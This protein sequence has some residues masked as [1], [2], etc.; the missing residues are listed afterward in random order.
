MSLELLMKYRALETLLCLKV[1]LEVHGQEKYVAT[2]ATLAKKQHLQQ[3]LPAFLNPQAPPLSTMRLYFETLDLGT[4]P[5]WIVPP[6]YSIYL[7][8]SEMIRCLLRARETVGLQLSKPLL[9]HWNIFKMFLS[10]DEIRP[11]NKLCAVFLRR[12]WA[13][14]SELLNR[15]SFTSSCTITS[16]TYTNQDIVTGIPFTDPGPIV[17]R[18]YHFVLLVQHMLQ[19]EL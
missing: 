17:S 7:T 9:Y 6:S 18:R 1:S 5:L 4:R 14:L 19:I 12:L 13:R 15:R 8:T 16:V 3:I 2:I 11:T 10:L